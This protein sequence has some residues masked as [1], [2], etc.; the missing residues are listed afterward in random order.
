[1]TVLGAALERDAAEKRLLQSEERWRQLVDA[2]PGPIIV[3]TEGKVAYVNKAAIDILGAR[4][5]GDVIGKKV[6]ALLPSAFLIDCQAQERDLEGVESNR[7]SGEHVLTGLD[8]IDRIVA[9]VSVPTSYESKPAVQIVLDNVT[10]RKAYERG[11]IEAKERAEDMNRMKTS[12]LANMSHEIRTPLTSIIGYASLIANEVNGKALEFAELIRAG[13]DR[14]M[15]TLISVLDFAQ[16]EG[17]TIRVHEEAIDLRN[18]LDQIYLL[19]RR[20]YKGKGVALKVERVDPELSAVRLDKRALGRIVINLVDNA[21]KFTDA[22]GSVKIRAWGDRD[23]DTV[24]VQVSDTGVGI[25]PAFLPNIFDAFK[26]QSEG[27]S[28]KFGGNGL[29]LAITHKLVGL[30]DGKIDVDSTVGEGT[31]FTVTLPW[32]TGD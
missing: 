32:K 22:T 31:T 2:H 6:T 27:L 3:C 11:L 25:D 29:G 8:G 28:R 7:L 14:L 4:S 20:R 15:D 19:Y 24:V 9:F 23:A 16:L 5:E 1:V 26:Q 17:G 30:M 18:E 10:E 13:A 12:F 21:L